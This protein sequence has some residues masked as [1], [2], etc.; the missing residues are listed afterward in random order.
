MS[1]L[2][3]EVIKTAATIP[4][5]IIILRVIFKKSI[6]FK[7]SMLTVLFTI[8]VVF[9]KT[10]EFYHASFWQYIVTPLNVIVG[11]FVMRYIN[12]M[13]K[14][15]L[16]TAIN[17]LRDLSNGNLQ[18]KVVKTDS[19]DEL[20][21]LN[22]ALV[23]LSNRLKEVMYEIRT[24]S[25]VLLEASHKLSHAAEEL[26]TGSN[27]QASS[28]EEVSSTMEEIAGNI[29]SNSDNAKETS[30]IAEASSTSVANVAHV[31]DE[32]NRA[33]QNIAEKMLVI[34]DIAMQTNILALNAAVEAARAG[35]MG[36]GFA[37]VASEVRKLAENSKKAADDIIHTAETTRVQ[38]EQ[39]HD[40]LN[41]M[42]PQVDRTAHLVREIAAASYE[43]NNGVDQVN[44][45]IQ[46]L[47]A[48]TQQNS[49]AAEE[50]ASSSEEL[51]QQAN[52][53]KESI[54]FFKL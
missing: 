4:I 50:M 32:S 44:S 20:G 9:M 12:K 33:V 11:V 45:A 51:T 47:N 30:S 7:F 22:N 2:M 39:A 42:K 36:R 38:T 1:E 5:A 16:E 18:L 35:E 29:A 3:I 26:S 52:S 31:S 37:I 53:L 15:P 49:A 34:N 10:I 27:E 23:N 8:F 21:V 43:Q 13:L 48:M 19:K 54:A 46:Q 6:M 25:D 28:L 24:G 14:I 40:L 41:T 17:E